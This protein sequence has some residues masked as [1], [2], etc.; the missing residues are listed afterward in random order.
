VVRVERQWVPGGKYEVEI[1]G[2]RNTT[3]VAGDVRGGF[4]VPKPTAADTTRL[5]GA[6]P[7]VGDST[8]RAPPRPK[9]AADSLKRIR[10]SLIRA[11]PKP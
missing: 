1:R 9:P 3:G 7:A 11:K 8:R 10:D 2:V 4:T 5:K 6:K